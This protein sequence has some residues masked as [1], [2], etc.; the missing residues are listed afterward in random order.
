MKLRTTHRQ[1]ARLTSILA[2]ALALG[3]L[4]VLGVV[5]APTAAAD[6][7]YLRPASGAYPLDGR[8]FGHGIGLSQYGARGA[9]DQGRTW[10]QIVGFYYPGTA[11]ADN[12]NPLIR[13]RLVG[14]T[15]LAVLADAGLRV[16]LDESTTGSPWQALPSTIQRNSQSL[17]VAAWDVA[18]YTGVDAAT[19]G[20]WLRFRPVGWT[21]M[22]N[23][24]M[25]PSTARVVAFDNAT[26][27]TVRKIRGSS[28]DTY[29]GELRHVRSAAGSTA[30]I[31][32]VA[33]LPME[34]Y[35]RGVV[36]NEMPASWAT[37]ALR[38]QS[39]AARTYA[40]FERRSA[41]STR[42]YDTCNTTACQVFQSVET[43]DT[44]ADA[45][46]T[47]TARQILTYSGGPAFTQF[48]AANGGFTVAGSRP[49]LVAKAD[50]YDSY[51]WSATVSAAAIE[52]AYPAIGR[53][54]AMRISQRDGNGTWGGRVRQLVLTGSST[55]VTVTGAAFRSALGLRSD[56]FKPGSALVSAPSFPRDVTSDGYGD[57]VA[58]VPSTGALLVYP[59]NGVGR[60]RPRITAATSGWAGLRL[61][62]SAGAWDPGAT[63][64]LMS[65]T[66]D[67]TLRW[68]GGRGDGTFGAGIALGSDYGDFTSMFT[69][70]DI[71]GDGG[72]DI[73][74]RT[75]DGNLWLLS[76][77]GQGTVLSRTQIGNGWASF[78]AVLSPGDWNGDR[79][80]DILARD[81]AGNLYLYAGAGSAR[82]R[83]AVRIGWGWG[84]LTSVTSVGDFSGDGK[85]D[86]IARTST[87]ALWLYPGNGTGGF[88]SRVQIGS[89]WNGLQI[90][91]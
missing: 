77:T 75:T 56:W 16:N 79:R 91:P 81:A 76:G 18:W 30:A 28:H 73:V 55:S 88:G 47:A 22:Y 84:S 69:M 54:T 10:Q 82:F 33:A 4:A 66:Q 25:S 26:T 70:G 20:W 24:A 23:Y 58:V 83:S 7:I 44:R 3:L 87:G 86:L 36:P 37:Q 74:G 59:G 85:A 13:V 80:A 6:E 35:L 64:D 43:E 61:A 57:V 53:L 19:T 51:T 71:D 8:G 31:T 38:A 27:G 9:A 52:R 17:Q 62:F 65:V 12:G 67:G 41:P 46:I 11:V 5:H 14:Q 63:V 40:E 21:S 68:H 42:V 50:P 45:A 15:S 60:F 49:Y 1:S 48:S 72:T 39:V 89:G 90:L 29:R 78:T 2:A 32:V 34:S